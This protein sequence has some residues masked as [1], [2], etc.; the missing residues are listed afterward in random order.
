MVGFWSQN[1]NPQHFGYLDPPG[2]GLRLQAL[3]AQE[4]SLLTAILEKM[5]PDLEKN[6]DMLLHIIHIAFASG[7][8]WLC[9]RA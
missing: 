2:Q 4:L 3:M 8:L 9:A 7:C 5:E 1:W 6:H